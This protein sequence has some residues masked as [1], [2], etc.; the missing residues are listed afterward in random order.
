[1][2]PRFVPGASLVDV[3]AYPGCF[4]GN[5][6]IYE[7]ASIWEDGKFMVDLTM[8]VSVGTLRSFSTPKH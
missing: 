4:F 8:V 3:G 5:C 1:M 2:R 7:A 6:E